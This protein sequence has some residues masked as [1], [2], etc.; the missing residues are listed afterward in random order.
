MIT[1]SKKSLYSFLV[2]LFLLCSMRVWAAAAC[3][4]E[5]LPAKIYLIIKDKNN[6]HHEARLNQI[7]QNIK[8][9]KEREVWKGQEIKEHLPAPLVGITLAYY[10]SVD[11]YY[12]HTGSLRYVPTSTIPL[13][14]LKIGFV[15]RS[16][17]LTGEDGVQV[18]IH[19]AYG[20]GVLNHLEPYA[21]YRISGKRFDFESRAI[22][23]ITRDDYNPIIPKLGTLEYL[24]F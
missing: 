3:Q 20:L 8:E 4:V 11:K 17:Y 2:F 21:L 18:Q 9:A 12:L 19:K 5:P 1:N 15:G 22:F 24:C 6:A 16:S 10:R 13:K 14:S 23:S 7:L